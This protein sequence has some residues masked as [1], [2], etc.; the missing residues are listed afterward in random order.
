M[1][2]HIILTN[3]GGFFVHGEADRAAF[4][5]KFY[6]VRQKVQQ[7][8]IDTHA[9]VGMTAIAT[10]NIGNTQQVQNCLRKITLSSR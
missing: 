4:R 8:L 1:Y 3:G 2:T 9:I 5:C 7:N 10:A 6:S